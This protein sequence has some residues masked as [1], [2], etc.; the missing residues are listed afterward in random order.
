MSVRLGYT[1]GQAIAAADDPWYVAQA[2]ERFLASLPDSDRAGRDVRA[3]LAQAEMRDRMW[4]E[5]VS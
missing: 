5:K 3:R 2:Y 4:A 1:I